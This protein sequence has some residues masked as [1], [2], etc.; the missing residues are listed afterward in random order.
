MA[1]STGNRRGGV[2][3]VLSAGRAEPDLPAL[4]DA[5]S[6]E[7]PRFA[8]PS[9]AVFPPLGEAFDCVSD[10]L[11]R[12][13]LALVDDEH[14]PT[15]VYKL[16]DHLWEQAVPAVLVFPDLTDRRRR[17]GGRGVIVAD[18]RTPPAQLA[19]A[20]AAL[21]E[22]QPFVESLRSELRVSRRF[23]GGL[24]GEMDKIHEELQL[25]AIVQREFLP[26]TIPA[27]PGLDL[28]VFFR[29]ASYVS[30]DIYDV[31]Q[32]DETRLGFFLADAVGHGV[33]AALMTMVLCKAL[34][35]KDKDG[36]VLPPGEVLERLNHDLISRHGDAPRFATAVYGIV[37]TNDNC[38]TLAGA[39]HPPPML[40]RAG[41]G[42]GAM[43]PI[44]TDGG[45]LGVF[46]EDAFEEVAF[47]LKP[48]EML[49]V[50][51]DGFETAFPGVAA[52]AYER[53]VPTR[54]F[55]R[56]FRT[57]LE[58][59][60][61]NGMGAGIE[62]LGAALNAQTGS[63]HQ[64]DDLTAILIAPSAAAGQQPADADRD[65]ASAAAA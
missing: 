5:I 41:E 4:W 11:G 43:R 38:V 18:D 54:E 6:A 22:R 48:D 20:L 40:Y 60:H 30:G 42:A 53:R 9:Q 16:V 14:D 46:P 1:A 10:V 45:L 32:L 21:A 64:I 3:T 31:Q 17:L 23:Q 7:W 57:V 44:E 24:R 28:E 56:Q 65:S 26:K 55:V 61:A 34:T 49:V 52:D 47:T 27:L 19:T 29:P 25:A 58:A 51:S 50:H 39:G 37:D 36:S 33:P 2:V 8:E 62:Q 63:L 59:W 35:T 15:A 12:A 13:V